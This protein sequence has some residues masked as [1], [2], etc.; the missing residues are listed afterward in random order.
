MIVLAFFLFVIVID[1]PTQ[2]FAMC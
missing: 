1:A 2:F